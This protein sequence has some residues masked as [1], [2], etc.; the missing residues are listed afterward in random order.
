MKN[1]IYLS[2]LCSL[3]VTTAFNQTFNKGKMDSLFTILSEKNKAMGSVAISK[4]G[5]IT[6]NRSIG[7]ASVKGEEKIPATTQTKYRIGSI[8]KT[9]TAV[10]I[11]QLIEE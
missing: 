10:I 11:F 6:Y 4:K 1:K 9:F 5:E 7:Y 2:I 3:L 8:T